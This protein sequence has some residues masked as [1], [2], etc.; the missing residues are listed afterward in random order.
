MSEK[1]ISTAPRG[2]PDEEAEVTGTATS[3][4][5]RVVGAGPPSTVDA[6]FAI[7]GMTCA[8]CALV[9][10][11]TIGKLAGVQVANVNLATERLSASFDPARISEAEI[12]AA[13][14]RAGYGAQPLA[15]PTGATAAADASRVTLDLVGMTCASCALIIEK[16]LGRVDGVE[17]AAVNLATETATVTFNPSLVGIE[18]L[19]GT[20]AGAGYQAAVRP[21]EAAAGRP[22]SDAQAR[23]QERHLRRER[24]LLVFSLVFAIP[25]LLI[26]MVPP[27]M[28]AVPMTV[29]NWLGA[30]VGGTWDPFM[31]GKYLGF[32][33]TTPVQFIAGARFYRG[34]WHAIKNRA[35][36]MDTLIA[37]GTSAAY[38]YS[39][40]ATFVPQPQL[41]SLSSTRRPHCSSP[42]F[43][44]ASCSRRAPKDARATRSRS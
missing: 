14:E 30:L 2:L 40:A 1:T 27:F 37:I 39:V 8:S 42:S 12:V 24:H 16:L 34:L 25:A 9:I 19:V 7:T 43:S 13:V 29:A 35:G 32:L 18:T 5:A 33:L 4:S 36:N 11:K 17:S 31:V 15:M 20:V 6:S 23:A 10:E 21:P 41:P 3:E 38:F 22:P 44:W 28:H 26:A